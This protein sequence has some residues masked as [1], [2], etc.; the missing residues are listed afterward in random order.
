MFQENDDKD[1]YTE[2]RS[3]TSPLS[4]SF[5]S[6]Q[7]FCKHAGK[8]HADAEKNASNGLPRLRL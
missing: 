3:Q 8:M 7:Y 2:K 6:K 5:S 4:F 1:K